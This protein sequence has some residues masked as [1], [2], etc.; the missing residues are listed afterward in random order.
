M[1]PMGRWC[2]LG[3]KGR[4]QSLAVFR[5]NVVLAPI[6]PIDRTKNLVPLNFN[7]LFRFP[8]RDVTCDFRLI[9]R[10]LIEHTL[11]FSTSGAIC[12]EP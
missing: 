3:L 9:R 11:L 12:I 2:G 8:V 5:K 10:S 6:C 1:E 7:V 4:L